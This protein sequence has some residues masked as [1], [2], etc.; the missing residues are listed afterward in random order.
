[1]NMRP[2]LALLAC[3]FYATIVCAQDAR[4]GRELIRQSIE[5]HHQ[6]PFIFETQSMILL[7][8]DGH[9]DV[10]QL[11]RYSRVESDGTI[12]LLLRFTAPAPIRGTTL[13]AIQH[14]DG[15]STRQLLL[16]SLA[17]K[18][19]DYRSSDRGGKFLGSDF[20]IEDLTPDRMD[21]YRY[22]RLDNETRDGKTW[23][24][25]DAL[26][27]NAAIAL[28]TGYQRRRIFIRQEFLL[29]DRIDYF[30]TGERMAKQMT[31]HDIQRINGNMW[32]TNMLVMESFADHHRSMLKINS[33]IFSKDYVPATMFAPK[34]VIR[35]ATI[36]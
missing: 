5:R 4:S 24:V 2:W 29:I 16:P 21:D 35:A 12:Q 27:K 33:R 20:S 10:R 34:Q 31:H 7:D 36:H 28:A 11:Q 25:I 19:I 26:P 8:Q 3:F 15:A 14:P 6:F 32:A 18:L 23:F 17:P 13:L 30:I 1:M 9:H 22:Q